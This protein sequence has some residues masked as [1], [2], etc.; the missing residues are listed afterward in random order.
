MNYILPEGSYPA[1]KRGGG[2]G[3]NLVVSLVHH[4]LMNY[5]ENNYK[6]LSINADSCAGQNKN[7]YVFYYLIWRVILGF[8]NNIQLSFML[9]GHTKSVV[10]GRFGLFKQIFSKV[11]TLDVASIENVIKNACLNNY[12]HNCERN[13]INYYDWKS[14][15]L[16][17]FNKAG[18]PGIKY[19]VLQMHVQ[20]K[21]IDMEIHVTVHLKTSS[22][23]SGYEWKEFMCLKKYKS[24]KQMF[25]KDVIN[26]YSL[27]QNFKLSARPIENDR[28]KY[29]IN[30][31]LAKYYVNDELKATFF[32]LQ[33]VV[34]YNKLKQ[35]MDK[36]Q[37]KKMKMKT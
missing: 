34:E 35:Q 23:D 20:R 7:K 16:Q 36:H 37:K 25:F 29:L 9:P 31:I 32:N 13:E 6:E 12:V 1:E 19:D 21:V 33:S 17:Y 30:E 26:S 28:K 2:K 10:D 11:D 15:L 5:Y 4:Y 27:L 22:L 3:C 18:V 14:F 8:E 24:R